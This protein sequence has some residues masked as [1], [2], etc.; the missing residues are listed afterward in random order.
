[1][2]SEEDDTWVFEMSFLKFEFQCWVGKR[3]KRFWCCLLQVE[4]ILTKIGNV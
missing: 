4:V 2:A 1:M 3:I